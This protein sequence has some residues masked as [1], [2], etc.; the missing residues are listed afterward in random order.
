MK[1]F[2]KVFV[3]IFLAIAIIIGIGWYL[4]VY[5]RDFTRDMLL[6]GARHFESEGNLN[7]ASWFYDRAY[8]QGSGSDEIAVELAQQYID[9]GN[10]TQAEVTL[11]RAMKDGGGISILMN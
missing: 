6:Q 5:D 11:N 7:V 2:L 10:Y 1:V 8:E 3:P 4:F 9:S